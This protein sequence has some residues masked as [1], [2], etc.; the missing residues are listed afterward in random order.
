VRPPPPSPLSRALAAMPE[1]AALE[2]L[3]EMGPVLALPVEWVAR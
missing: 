3:S 1:L 2:A